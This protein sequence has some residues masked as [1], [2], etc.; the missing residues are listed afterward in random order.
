MF[1]RLQAQQ[2]EYDLDV[3]WHVLGVARDAGLLAP[4]ALERLEI[5]A[6]PPT[7]TFRDQLDQTQSQ[8]I[9]HEAGILSSQTWSQL[10]GLDYDLE[11]ANFT[12]ADDKPGEP[13]P[14]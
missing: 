11:Q 10:C 3:M 12:A 13:Q 5:R 6:V 9:Q 1:Q 14:S 7:L 8:K 4:D 2:V